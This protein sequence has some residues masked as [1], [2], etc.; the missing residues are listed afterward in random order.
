MKLPA[1]YT[2]LTPG[3][4]KAAREQYVKEQ[5]GLCMYCLES[6][7]NKAPDRI[8]NAKISINLFPP[9]FFNHP[10]HLQHCHKTGMTEGA[11]HSHCNAYLWQYEGR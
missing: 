10:I 8:R 5:G 4:R 7:A 3:K 2:K 11:V 1:D 6:L 9:G